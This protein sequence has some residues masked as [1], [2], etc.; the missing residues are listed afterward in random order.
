MA[1]IKNPR[2][3]FMWSIQ[4]VNIPI[5]PYL[6]QKVGIPEKGIEQVLHGDVNR[7]VKTGGRVTIGNMTAEK[8]LTT[9]GSDTWLWDWIS[10][11][12][13]TTLGGGLTPDQYWKTV[14][15][16][17]LAEDGSSVL[18]QWIL[19]EVW[20]TKLNEQSLDRMSS[21]NSIESIEFSVGSIDKI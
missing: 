2:K 11:V 9:S 18:N 19:T 4:F 10:S 12:A 3:N 21:E 1:K 17:E 20:P 8:L 15:V 7:D 5:N 14:I 6:F 16:S 13:D